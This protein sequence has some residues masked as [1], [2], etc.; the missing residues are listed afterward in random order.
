[1][2]KGINKQMEKF[3]KHKTGNFALA[4]YVKRNSCF[5]EEFIRENRLF[6]REKFPF[7]F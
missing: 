5:Y 3:K 6:S 4:R 2:M 1:M 7:A